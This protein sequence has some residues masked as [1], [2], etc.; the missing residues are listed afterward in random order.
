MA[1]S[2]RHHR[3]EGR[4]FYYCRA[5]RNSSSRLF[6]ESKYIYFGWEECSSIL[7]V[8]MRCWIAPVYV[9]RFCIVYSIKGHEAEMVV[10]DYRVGWRRIFLGQLGNGPI[11]L[12]TLG[13]PNTMFLYGSSSL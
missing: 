3:K 12:P 7:N 2:K 10:V 8:D 11:D 6:G 9:L 4:G 5:S 1:V 13:D